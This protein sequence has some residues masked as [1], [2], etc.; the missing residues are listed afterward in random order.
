MIPQHPIRSHAECCY[1]LRKRLGIQSNSLQSIDIDGNDDRNNKF[2]VG[3]DCEKLL[4]VSFTGVNT[5]N[6]LVTI[7][8]KTNESN[9]GH[10]MHILL[11][12]EQMP[13]VSDSGIT[14]YD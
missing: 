6:S 1:S 10:G 11:T 4:G 9:R 7:K 13:E 8:L 14:V 12:S 2:I 5:K 3:L